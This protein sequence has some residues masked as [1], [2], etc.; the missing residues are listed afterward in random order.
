MA[1][2]AGGVENLGSYN[3]GGTISGGDAVKIDSN[4]DV[5]RVDSAGEGFIGICM[6]DVSSGDSVA[7]AE[8]GCEVRGANV[9]DAATANDTLTAEGTN[10]GRL[11]ASGTTGDT[12][13]GYAKTDAD[14]N[15]E[16]TIMVTGPAGEVN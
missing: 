3:A 1:E 7:V 16:A 8:T 15:N 11:K 12:T 14:S 9:A 2:L 5:V 13:G 6:Y 4:G 10:N